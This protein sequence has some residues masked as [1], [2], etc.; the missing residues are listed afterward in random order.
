MLCSRILMFFHDFATCFGSACVGLPRSSVPTAVAPGVLQLE[1]RSEKTE[2]PEFSPVEVANVM[3]VTLKLSVP[4][5][6]FGWGCWRGMFSPVFPACLCLE[7]R[8][9]SL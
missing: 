1:R 3:K 6:I 8:F 5:V 7:T 9:Q 4:V 2:A